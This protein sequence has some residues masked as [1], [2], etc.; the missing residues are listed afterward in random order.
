[1]PAIGEDVTLSGLVTLQRVPGPPAQQRPAGLEAVP[2]MAQ[3]LE[4]TEPACFKDEAQ[5]PLF[6]SVLLAPSA[7]PSLE[8]VGI[9]TDRIVRVQGIR[10][11]RREGQQHWGMVIDVHQIDVIAR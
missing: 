3:V 2:D 7:L 5:G 10:T 9:A 11:P 8:Q 6:R 1:M 4:L